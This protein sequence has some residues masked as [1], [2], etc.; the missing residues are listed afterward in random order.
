MT[1]LKKEFRCTQH[2]GQTI[3]TFVANADGTQYITQWMDSCNKQP[4]FQTNPTSWVRNIL[5]TL[6]EV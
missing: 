2:N 5:N 6:Q 3:F 1:E 4:Q